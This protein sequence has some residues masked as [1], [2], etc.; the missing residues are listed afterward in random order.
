LYVL[1]IDVGTTG[2]KAILVDERGS[3]VSRG[4]EAY[5]LITPGKGRVEQDARLWWKAVIASVRQACAGIAV[6]DVV[7]LS[8]STQGAS[9]LLVDQEGEALANALTWMDGR[10]QEEAAELARKLGAES[11]YRRTG[12][13]AAP[14]LD[15][16]KL[17]WLVKHEP[18]LLGRSAKFLS[19]LEYINWKLVGR[20]VIDPTNA[21]I[22]QL[23]NL[24]TLD[25]D[26]DILSAIEA[27]IRLLPEL[28]PSGEEIGVLR[29]EAA[30]AL[31]LHEG[32]RVFNGAHDQYCACLGSSITKPGEIML[33]TG[34][35]WVL[36]AVTEKPLY[37]AS[38]ICPG[39][40]IER[41]KWGALTAMGT[42][43]AGLEW[44]RAKFLAEDW[45]GLTAHLDSG[46]A[47][48]GDLFFLPWLAGVGF[49]QPRAKARAAFLGLGLEHDRYDAAKAVME[50]AVFHMRLSLE[51]YRKS[52]CEAGSMRVMGGALNSRFWT[53]AIGYNA[54]C[55][56]SIMTETDTACIGAAVMAGVGAGFFPDSR[57]AAGIM[58]R[59]EI[60]DCGDEA[61][62][63]E[64]TGKFER[65]RGAWTALSTLY[66]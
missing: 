44:F 33:S 19:T 30:E 41:G 9:S 21:A 42:A 8:L 24:E 61:T 53:N 43:G 54:G 64:Y 18:G 4:Y 28:V 66:D 46:P 11:V 3:L 49:P 10:A 40:H 52:G 2:T 58:N 65:Y 56:V 12:W 37:T 55:E 63:R 26:G 23:M 13:R 17:R 20:A 34:T 29:K 16:A 38:H 50:G 1:G 59:A 14:S 60:L 32:V 62:R 35:A 7:A 22:R 47:G 5:G 51:E 31:G 45:A 27:D 39:P 36:M 15:A 6:R 57:T 48:T 25:W